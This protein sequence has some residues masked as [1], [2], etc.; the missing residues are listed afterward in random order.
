MASVAGKPL[1]KRAFSTAYIGYLLGGLSLLIRILGKFWGL[2]IWQVYFPVYVLV[3][4]VQNFL[5]SWIP[6]P[7][8][9]L[10]LPGLL[11]F[12]GFQLRKYWRKRG[13]R[14]AIPRWQRFRSGL[15]KVGNLAGALFFLF[16]FLWG[17][18]YLHNPLAPH[19]PK[20][21]P[22]LSAEALCIE[23]EWAVRNAEIARAA[24]P[25]ATSDS[26]SARLIPGN[27][28]ELVDNA[29]SHLLDSLQ[30]P[31]APAAMGKEIHPH[32]FLLRAGIAG[33]YNPFT[34]EGNIDA[35]MIAALKPEVL[36]HEM[37]HGKGY[38]DE[39]TCNFLGMLACITSDAPM[40]Q[41]S[42]YLAYYI[43]VSSDLFQADP[44]LHKMVRIT[45]DSAMVSDLRAYRNNHIRYR[46]WLSNVGEAVNHA[47]LSTQGVSGGITNYGKV[48]AYMMAYE[49]SKHWG[50]WRY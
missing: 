19:L 12:L 30:L 47:Y 9:Y 20:E 33:I 18:N 6:F 32:G 24:I 2:Q 46:G 5:F 38:T 26:I 40:L 43:Y 3:R 29:L 34:G 15:R 35:G 17:F 22:S 42:G 41:Y 49:T 25:G 7:L 11:V 37:S 8:V 23:A 13:E 44:Q 48:V 39:G 4:H 10:W 31:Q 36:A 14:K 1:I 16:H 28:R 21:K 45:A 27:Y 50:K